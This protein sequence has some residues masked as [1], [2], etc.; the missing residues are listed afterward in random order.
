M[1]LISITKY[2]I[3]YVS[4][5]VFQLKTIVPYDQTTKTNFL[6]AEIKILTSSEKYS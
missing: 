2:H 1:E 4:V 5:H 6:D 3:K